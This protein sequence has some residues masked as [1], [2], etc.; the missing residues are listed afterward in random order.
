MPPLRRGE[1]E[2]P[3]ALLTRSVIATSSAGPMHCEI[4]IVVTIREPGLAAAWRLGANPN[5][6]NWALANALHDQTNCVLEPCLDPNQYLTH[7]GIQ[8]SDPATDPVIPD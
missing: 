7:Q 5:D 3:E 4:S 8:F 2:E 6:V 1:I